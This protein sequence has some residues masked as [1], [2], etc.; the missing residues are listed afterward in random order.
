MFKRK[1]GHRFPA[2]V[3]PTIIRDEHGNILNYIATIKDLTE[4]SQLESQLRQAQKMEAVGQLTGGIAHDFNNLLLPILGYAELLLTEINPENPYYQEILHI[5]QAG[6][7]ARDLTAQLLAFSRK[8][9]MEMKTVDLR[10]VITDFQKIL[11]RTVREDIAIRLLLSSKPH[12]VMAD[13]GKIGQILMNLAVN[14]QDAMPQGG[15]ITIEATETEIDETYTSLHHGA[16]PGTYVMLSF[17]DCGIGMDKQTIERLFE[18]FFTTKEPGKGTG[19]GLSTVFGIVKQHNG[20]IMVYSEPGLGTTF[21]VYLPKAAEKELTVEEPVDS[22]EYKRGT[23]TVL[24]VEDDDTVRALIG[25]IL[26]KHG[27][28]VIDFG[29]AQTC[30]QTIAQHE[31]PIDLLLTDI[32]MPGVNGRQLQDRLSAD[33]PGLKVIFMSGYPFDVIVDHGVLMQGI[34]FISKPFTARDLTDKVRSVLDEGAASP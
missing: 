8:Q 11:R 33:I 10:D 29:N 12:P 27:Y 14:A 6:E 32:I 21:K 9:I 17:S 2:L 34:N 1:N 31:G 15:T 26:R 23:E 28:T 25:R 20:Y 19:L 24:V 18:P 7:K 4:F 3:S 16:L 5:K 22:K 30:L 13:T